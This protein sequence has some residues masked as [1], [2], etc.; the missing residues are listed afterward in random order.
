MI[1]TC[2]GCNKTWGVTM[3]PR[4]RVLCTECATPKPWRNPVLYWTSRIWNF[5]WSHDHV[6]SAEWWDQQTALA[7]LRIAA[8]NAENLSP[9]ACWLLPAAFHDGHCC[10]RKDAP[11]DCHDDEGFALRE[12]N[13]LSGRPQPSEPALTQQL[14][15]PAQRTATT[16]RYEQT[17]LIGE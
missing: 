7:D 15:D 3:T 11:V 5:P 12:A 10:F 13:G 6:R 9:C 1:E 16:T 8:A 4:A 2:I 14:A 17:A